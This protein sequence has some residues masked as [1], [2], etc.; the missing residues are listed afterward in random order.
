MVSDLTTV[1]EIE[2]ELARRGLFPSHWQQLAYL[3]SS[4]LCCHPLHGSDTMGDLQVG[5]L[6]HLHLRC[7][8]L[9]GSGMRI[10]CLVCQLLKIWL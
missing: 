2:D 9:G 10:A 1:N 5:S 4:G 6:S 7:I 3:S 8:F